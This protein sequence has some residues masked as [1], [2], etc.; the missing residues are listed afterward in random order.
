MCREACRIAHLCDCVI[1]FSVFLFYQWYHSTKQTSIAFMI[2]IDG[3]EETIPMMK[4]YP[5][6]TLNVHVLSI[7]PHHLTEGCSINS[8][9]ALSIIANLIFQMHNGTSF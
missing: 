9:Q 8:S 1:N 5:F 7:Q 2:S 6:H 3:I 4:N